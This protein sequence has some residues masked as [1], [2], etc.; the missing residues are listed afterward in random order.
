MP[1][2]EFVNVITPEGTV[3]HVPAAQVEQLGAGYRVAT[4]TEI[5]E[6]KL[7]EEYGGLGHQAAAFGAGALG[8][9]TFG[10]SNVALSQSEDIRRAL[11]AYRQ[12]HGGTL[13]AGEIGGGLLG[14]GLSG[15]TGALAKGL[16]APT[17][18]LT[19]LSGGAERLA[20]RAP[21]IAGRLLA[22]A[23]G[24]AIEAGIETL[25]QTIGESYVQNQPL[26]AEKLAAATGTGVLWGGGIGGGVGLGGVALGK[27]GQGLRRLVGAPSG[28]DVERAAAGIFGDAAPGLGKRA[29]DFFA[30]VSATAAGKDREAMRVFMDMGAQGREAR[31][32][33]FEGAEDIDTIAARMADALDT[34]ERAFDDTF[35]SAS[36]GF[37]RDAVKRSIR[38]DNVAEQLAAVRETYRRARDAFEEIAGDN[39]R[40]FNQAAAKKL[41]RRIHHFE[42]RLTEAAEA[43]EDISARAYSDFDAFKQEVQRHTKTVRNA[44]QRDGRA[45]ETLALL[46]RLDDEAFRPMLQSTELWGQVGTAQRMI[47]SAWHEGLG[48]ALQ[49]HRRDMMTRYG[50]VAD[51]PYGPLAYTADR[52]KISGYLRGLDDPNRNIA[53]QAMAEALQFKRSYAQAALDNL[54]LTPEAAEKFKQILASADEV[55]KLASDAGSKVSLQNQ[56]QKIASEDGS[57]V[58]GAALG[59]GAGYLLGGEEGTAAALGGAALGAALNPG[60]AI[61]RMAAIERMAAKFD[62]KVS[63]SVRK[64]FARAKPAAV[65]IAAPV[66]RMQARGR[67]RDERVQAERREIALRQLQAQPEVARS[68]LAG[69]FNAISG[70]APGITQLAADT[71]MRGA[72]YLRALMPDR[73]PLGILD[74]PRPLSRAEGEQLMRRARAIEEPWSLAS[75]AA[76]GTLTPGMVSAV[77]QVYPEAFADMQAQIFDQLMAAQEAGKELPYRD[78][79]QLS[80]LLQSPVVGSWDP[81]VMAAA[82][83]TFAAPPS[84]PPPPRGRGQGI[85]DFGDDMLTSQQRLER[86][87]I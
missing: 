26:T 1:D 61:R 83:A 4:P 19:A 8:G 21:G 23:V 35:I 50:N 33:I 82:Q 84:Q 55:E 5:G 31:R 22:P 18:A 58:L 15:G 14:L 75:S 78:A 2:G 30:D 42:Q 37:K 76:D 9:L 62:G 41:Q 60:L 81:R 77:A 39:T 79:G 67:E 32:L 49:R 54:E 64:A 29:T 65:K 73:S 20:A 86:E 3:G 52:A 16:S 6:A 43:G 38:T 59:A 40:H 69:A 36:S 53:H 13:V 71:T 7:E 27:L 34:G 74:A 87:M 51:D 24:G 63:A 56:F 85:P 70:T 80:V 28:A 44:T 68:E 72:D 11:Q 10:L 47:N 57:G 46:R 48:G 45:H 12:V 66:A 17:R 25:G